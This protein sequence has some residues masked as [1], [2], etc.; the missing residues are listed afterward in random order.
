MKA[1][2]AEP[3]LGPIDIRPYIDLVDW[4]IVGSE[5]GPGARPLALDWVRDIRDVAKAHEKPFF[6]KQ[7]GS[8]HKNQVRTLD[9][10]TWD[11]FPPGWVK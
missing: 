6:I 7:L 2:V 8:S 5:T 10:R 3:L 4:V 1:L 9:G 11:Q